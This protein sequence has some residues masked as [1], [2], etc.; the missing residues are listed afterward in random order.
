MATAQS[1]AKRVR[2]SVW[3]VLPRGNR[4]G[5]V[6]ATSL[7]LAPRR[8]G[9]GTPWCNSLGRPRARANRGMFWSA[10]RRYG[11]PRPGQPLA[12]GRAPGVCRQPQVTSPV[13]WSRAGRCC[14]GRGT[15]KDTGAEGGER[16]GVPRRIV[17]SAKEGG[18]IGPLAPTNITAEVPLAGGCTNVPASCR[19]GSRRCRDCPRSRGRNCRQGQAH[20]LLGS[21]RQQ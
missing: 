8:S 17:T 5:R 6:V 11:A 2:D 3:R 15:G 13:R 7:A 19:A 12:A 9:P 1:G 20:S 14:G 18:S 16:K 10:G 21:L 4:T